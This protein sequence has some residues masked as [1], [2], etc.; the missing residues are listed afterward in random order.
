[1]LADV[2]RLHVYAG[3]CKVLRNHIHD[4]ILPRRS[5]SRTPIRELDEHSVLNLD[6]MPELAPGAGNGMEQQ[7]FDAT[8][9]VWRADATEVF[10]SPVLVADLATAG[11]TL[12]GA[13]LALI[14]AFTKLIL[15]QRQTTGSGQPS[16]LLMDAFQALPGETEP[17]LPERAHFHSALFGWHPV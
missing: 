5:T 6:A 12:M 13:G 7:H 10:G 9:G 1:V 4:G 17:R 8:R 14:E 2:T 11:H 16:P 15:R 3:V